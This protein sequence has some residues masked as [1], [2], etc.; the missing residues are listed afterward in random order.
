VAG[1]GPFGQYS[2]SASREGSSS[3][4]TG[5]T[6]SITKG[7]NLSTAWGLNTSRAVGANSSLA[8]STQRSREF[9]VEQH[10]LQQLPPSA[11]IVSYASRS[12]RRV[13]MADANPGILAL[14]AATLRSLEDMRGAA[15]MAPGPGGP[16]G[17]GG[18]AGPGAA[19]RPPA[20][21]GV[22]ATGVP[23]DSAAGAAGPVPP[24][25]RDPA[26]APVSW[27]DAEA[28][29]PPNLGPPPEPLDWRKHRR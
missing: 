20:V 10:E 8:R 25:T 5:E 26:A 11:M 3:W 22:A 19:W 1:F 17:A 16:A 6:E 2:R 24:P 7:I 23:D 18:D 27:R 28:K 9:L 21:G 12:G 13:V 15:A 29:L 14:P 4:N